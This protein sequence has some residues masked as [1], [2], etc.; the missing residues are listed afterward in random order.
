MFEE[1]FATFDIARWSV[2]GMIS[3]PPGVKAPA[4]KPKTKSASWRGMLMLP[5]ATSVM[6]F[7]VATAEIAMQNQVVLAERNFSLPSSAE[8]QNNRGLEVF[9]SQSKALFADL[10]ANRRP[11]VSPETLAAARDA[12]KRQ[13]VINSSETTPDWI[14]AMASRVSASND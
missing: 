8:F 3:R 13:I 6:S 5:A 4:S 2:D 7:H 14:A 10:A 11:S 12:V 1:I 9:E